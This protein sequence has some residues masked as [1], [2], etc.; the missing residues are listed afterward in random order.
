M[1]VTVV[2]GLVYDTIQSSYPDAELIEIH[3]LDE[4]VNTTGN[5][6]LA[7]LQNEFWR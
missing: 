3:V 1:V 6:L 5:E 7:H 2:I 4:F